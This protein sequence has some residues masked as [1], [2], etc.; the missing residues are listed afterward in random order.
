MDYSVAILL[1]DPKQSTSSTFNLYKMEFRSND[2]NSHLP[3]LQPK[4]AQ[5]WKHSPGACEGV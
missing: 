4:I 1:T 5:V 3:S 2:N